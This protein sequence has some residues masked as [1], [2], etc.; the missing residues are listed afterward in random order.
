[1]RDLLRRGPQDPEGRPR[2]G[3]DELHDRARRLRREALR[4]G[5]LG[6]ALT[7]AQALL[8]QALAAEREKLAPHNGG[9]APVAQARPDALPRSTARAGGELAG[10]D[11]ANDQA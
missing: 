10:Q 8:D 4:R 9:D 6:G 2:G 7:R 5:R 1:M 3:L 11:W